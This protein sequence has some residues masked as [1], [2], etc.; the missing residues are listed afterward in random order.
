MDF[1][2]H[3]S[4]TQ[5]YKPNEGLNTI[6]QMSKREDLHMFAHGKIG[7]VNLGPVTVCLTL[8]LSAICPKIKIKKYN[9]IEQL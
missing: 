1:K 9:L 2:L 3:T 8:N 7:L 4:N 6:C 5:L